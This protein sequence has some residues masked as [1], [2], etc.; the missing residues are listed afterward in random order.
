MSKT[1][2]RRER[3]QNGRNNH[4]ALLCMVNSRNYAKN[5]GIIAR[6]YLVSYYSRL[7][8]YNGEKGYRKQ[9]G[10]GKYIINSQDSKAD[11]GENILKKIL[12]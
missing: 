11:L 2:S 10:A 6:D 5:M 9:S 12:L 7:I 8:Y 4:Y 1:Y 3:W